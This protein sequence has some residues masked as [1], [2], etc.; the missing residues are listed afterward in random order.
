MKKVLYSLIPPLVLILSAFS[1]VKTDLSQIILSKLENFRQTTPQEKV[2]LHLDKPYYMAGDTLWVK[3]Y[4]F[5][6]ITHDIDSASRILY[7][8]LSDPLTG[9]VI[10]SRMLRCNG[11][12]YGDIALSDTLSEGIYQIRA[13][14]NYMRNF[15]EEFFFTQN[16]KIWQGKVKNRAIDENVSQLSEVADLQFFPE[17]GNSVVG[18]TSRV[19]FKG[20]NVAGKGIDFQGFILNNTNDTVSSFQSEH[21]GLGYFSYAP[22]P[23]KTYTAFVKQKNGEFRKFPLPNACKQGFAMAVDN[24]RDKENIRI[25][26]SNSN[27]KKIENSSELLVTVHL[28]GQLCFMG[29]GSNSKSSFNLVIPKNKIVD[30][31]IVQITLF[32]DK[33]EPLCERLVFN[34]L[35]RNLDLKITP[36]KNICK[37]REKVTLSLEAKDS[38]GKPVKGNFSVAVT[39]GSQ[40]ITEPNQEN[41][42]TYLLLSSDVSNL[43]NNDNQLRGKIEDPAYYF[44]KENNNAK[45]H[46]DLLMMTQGWRR[47]VW[48]DLLNNE[49]IKQKY[50]VE[51]GL[52]ITGNVLQINGRVPKK[53]SLTMMLR[54]N[55]N[56]PLEI[57]TGTIDSVGRYGFYGLD[58]SDTAKVFIQATKKGFGKLDLT[59]DKPK[60]SPKVQIVKIPFKPIEYSA[61][62][63]ADY[64]K[65]AQEALELERKLTL[66]KVQMLEEVVVRAKKS[67]NETRVLYQKPT[68]SVKVT[69]NLCNSIQN[70]LSMMYSI[71]GASVTTV[72]GDSHVFFRRGIVVI[73]A[74]YYFDGVKVDANYMSFINPCEIEKVDILRDADADVYRAF[75]VIS[76][77]TKRRSPTY[78]YSKEKIDGIGIAKRAGYHVPKEFYAPKYDADS[79][80]FRPD[81]RSTLHWQPNVRTDANGKATITYWNTDAQAKINV[82]AQGVSSQ[83]QVGVG[84]VSYQVK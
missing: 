20:V 46:L 70:I 83:G 35:N 37:M 58:F 8:D 63:L 19:G 72:E 38:N 59:I 12:T 3:G 7:V 82:Y 45:R 49:P 22:E 47:F 17:G 84:E 75:A 41:L 68:Y 81:Y 6:G 14:T 71:P 4:L 2:F 30:E 13:Y 57:Q 15:S 54:D 23:E 11:N 61:E 40:V 28:R 50:F 5:D 48:K 36:D 21:L 1:F 56:Q 32:D 55:N 16:I 27:P 67:D 31:G 51:S 9:K 33:G 66:N 78:D 42:L 26:I 65:K 80:N 77:L 73:E 53:L 24:V 74:V 44:K 25:L 52:E 62:D 60:N 43:Q 64:L 18:L 76:V 69:E 34:S 39:D 79:P 10:S 29:K